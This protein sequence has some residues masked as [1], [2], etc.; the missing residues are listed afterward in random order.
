MVSLKFLNSDN[1]KLLLLVNVYRYSIFTGVKKRTKHRRWLGNK[2]GIKLRFGLKIDRQSIER[3]F[4]Q[5]FRKKI[6]VRLKSVLHTKYTKV[7]EISKHVL[8]VSKRD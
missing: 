6:S 5:I 8:K 3:F 4:F 7:K 1:S 2:P